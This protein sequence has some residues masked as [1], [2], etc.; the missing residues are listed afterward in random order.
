M[1]LKEALGRVASDLDALGARWALVGGL[2]VGVRSEPRFTRDADF[3]V[4]VERDTGAED[5]VRALFA[6]GYQHVASLE[7]ELTG[8]L[9]TVRLLPPHAEREGVFADFLFASCGIEPEVVA[10]A[11]EALVVPGV[12]SRVASIGHLVAMKILSERPTRPQDGQDLLSLLRR[13]SPEDIAVAEASVGLIAERG[14]ARG[15]DLTGTLARYRALA[16][17]PE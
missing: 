7:Q 1:D 6:R 2:A 5:L 14:Y 17:E 16:A 3:A 9:A 12:R 8:R 13:A 11:T 15:K 4:A 10:S